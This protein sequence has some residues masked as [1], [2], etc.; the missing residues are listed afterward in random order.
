[1]DGYS[2]VQAGFVT[3]TFPCSAELISTAYQP[4][5]GVFL[6]QQISNSRLISQKKQPAEQGR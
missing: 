2:T 6:S 3:L 5:N 1:M 4:W